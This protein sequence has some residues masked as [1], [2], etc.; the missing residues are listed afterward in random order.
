QRGGYDLER[1]A[2]CEFRDQPADNRERQRQTA[3]I[4]WRRKALAT[5]PRSIHHRRANTDVEPSRLMSSP[6]YGS[7]WAPASM[8]GDPIGMPGTLSP[9]ASGFS[10][11]RRRISSAGT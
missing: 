5:R 8:P 9:M 7:L 11:S 6:S 10:A 1:A 2:A 4:E 3:Y